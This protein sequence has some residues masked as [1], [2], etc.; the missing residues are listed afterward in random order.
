MTNLI[1]LSKSAQHLS[2]PIPQEIIHFVE[3]GRNPDIYTR[4][5][6]EVVMRHNQAQKGRSE[7]LAKF[8]DILGEQIVAGIPEMREDVKKVVEASGGQL[9]GA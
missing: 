9:G 8:R 4:E 7:A 3:D 6:V 5:F 1:T 2:T